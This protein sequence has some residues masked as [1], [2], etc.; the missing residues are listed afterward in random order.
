MQ[1]PCLIVTSAP[2]V[3]RGEVQCDERS[4]ALT[5][6]QPRQGIFEE[7]QAFALGLAVSLYHSKVT[8]LRMIHFIDNKSSKT[9]VSG[10]NFVSHALGAAMRMR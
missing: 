2:E 10:F 3:I 9:N 8:L 4:P 6:S 5:L 7:V 1:L